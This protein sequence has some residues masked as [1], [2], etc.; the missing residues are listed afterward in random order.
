MT[1]RMRAVIFDGELNVGWT[2][3]PDVARGEALERGEV[4]VGA[5][6]DAVFPLE[7]AAAFERA[8]EPGALKVL[9]RMN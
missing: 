9:L 2:P 5:L 6:I 3:I 7:A 1:E 8:S 4:R